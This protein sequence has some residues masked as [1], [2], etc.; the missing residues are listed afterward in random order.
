MR[1]GRSGER[2]S[3][4]VGR[5][6]RRGLHSLRGSGKHPEEGRERPKAKVQRETACKA[7][8]EVI[9]LLGGS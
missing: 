5:N 6:N 4:N 3:G 9:P 1:W 8:Q 7:L 2:R